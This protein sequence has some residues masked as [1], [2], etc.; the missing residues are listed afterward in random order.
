M[1]GRVSVSARIKSIENRV[2]QEVETFPTVSIGSIIRAQRIV[3]LPSC[4]IPVT[5]I[6]IL[7]HLRM[8]RLTTYPPIAVHHS[9]LTNLL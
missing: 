3:S 4:R 7:V 5:R 8:C 1:A 9:S 2:D 6:Y